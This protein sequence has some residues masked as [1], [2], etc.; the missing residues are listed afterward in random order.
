MRALHA[1]TYLIITSAYEVGIIINFASHM[2][3]LK[4]GGDLHGVTQQE[5]VRVGILR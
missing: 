1:L 2:G 5:R 3:R 4:P